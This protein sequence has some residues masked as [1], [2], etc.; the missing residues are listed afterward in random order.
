MHTVMLQETQLS[1]LHMRPQRSPGKHGTPP[2][3]HQRLH[4]HAL[5]LLLLLVV[6]GHLDRSRGAHLLRQE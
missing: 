4:L 6:A 3:Q 2:Q 1:T 5:P